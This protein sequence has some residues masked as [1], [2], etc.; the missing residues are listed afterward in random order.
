MCSSNAYPWDGRL[1]FGLRE[2]L[3]NSLSYGTELHFH[4]ESVDFE[5]GAW[6]LFFYRF[7]LMGVW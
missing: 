3:L 7:F 1:L 6:N 4:K 5:K 2:K